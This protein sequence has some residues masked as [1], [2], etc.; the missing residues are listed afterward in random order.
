M[1]K[2]TLTSL[3]CLTALIAAGSLNAQS[4]KLQRLQPYGWQ[5]VAEGTVINLG[6]ATLGR[7]L[8]TKGVKTK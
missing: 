2:S 6:T 1:K 5:D 8:T 7:A 4:L 3:F